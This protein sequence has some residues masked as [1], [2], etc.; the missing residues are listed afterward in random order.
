MKELRVSFDEVEWL[1][2]LKAK[3]GY[4]WRRWILMKG[5]VGNNGNKTRSKRKNT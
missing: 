4:T 5:N 1:E 3:D 2:L